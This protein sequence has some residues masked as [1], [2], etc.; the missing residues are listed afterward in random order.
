[1]ANDQAARWR[2]RRT[3]GFRVG[4]LLPLAGLA[5]F[6]VGIYFA[7]RETWRRGEEVARAEAAVV[8]QRRELFA[9]GDFAATW[10]R[11][12]ED[13]RQSLSLYT[14]PQALAWSREGLTAYLVAGV[15]AGSWRQLLC[16]ENGVRR[17][18]RVVR[19]LVEL[20][21]A[22]VEAVDEAD[23]ELPPGMVV[24]MERLAAIPL[25]GGELAGEVVVHPATGVPLVR[26]WRGLEGGARAEL[27]LAAPD[28][29][30]LLPSPGFVFAPDVAVP[31]PLRALAPR[32]FAE[33]SQEAFAILERELPAGAKIS[34]LRLDDE[35]IE[36]TIEA[37]IPGL[38]G[39]PPAAY[40]D[41]E[42]DEYGVADR[43]WWYPRESP[44][45]GCPGGA[46]L[47]QVRTEL[48]TA[49]AGFHASG[50][51]TAWYSCSPAW[52]DGRRGHWHL[53]AR[54]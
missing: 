17:G 45:F 38:D 11:C 40:G 47:E 6:G 9:R 1:M 35:G 48:A 24:G 29:P 28:F 4:S 31:A 52:S 30:L 13:W 51:L 33:Q 14:R 44:S 27:D 39:A 20:V 50:V 37:A 15:D 54:P 22:E 49:K 8:A 25:V 42:W 18:P 21:P 41:L 23:A 2:R 26:R 34:E 46:P 16:D 5:V 7:E 43:D 53:V 36:V 12:E 19:P 10:A 3:G 32:R